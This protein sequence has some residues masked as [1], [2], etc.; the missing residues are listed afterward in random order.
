MDASYDTDLYPQTRNSRTLLSLVFCIAIGC[1]AAIAAVVLGARSNT[2]II[3][4]VVAA[5]ALP[6]G[7]IILLYNDKLSSSLL[8]AMLALSIP[9]NLDINLFYRQHVGGAPS[10]TIN[11]TLILIVVFF[12]VWVYRYAIRRPEEHNPDLHTTCM[13]RICIACAATFVAGKCRS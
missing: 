7:F 1:L 12:V 5:A 6:V 3:L 9:F 2:I 8:I 4:G 13:G 11:L 10:I